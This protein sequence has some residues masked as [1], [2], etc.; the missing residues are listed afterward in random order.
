MDTAQDTIERSIDI[1][2][3]VGR[4][5]SIVSVPGWWI[6]AGTIVAHRI[7]EREDGMSVVHDDGHGA[8]MIETERLD[9]PRYAAF[10][11]HGREGED[12][13][14]TRTEFWITDRPGGGVSLRV[15]ESGLAAIDPERRDAY[16]KENVEGWELELAAAKAVA[17]Q[18]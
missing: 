9:P 3:P 6:N 14:P 18:E 11:W 4:V 17:E 8:F 2:A 5:W 1:D 16:V 7:E 12:D 10:R 15:V 13:P